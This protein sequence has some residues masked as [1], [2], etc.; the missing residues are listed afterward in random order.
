MCFKQIFD[1]L[2][3]IFILTNSLG[4][5]INTNKTGLNFFDKEELSDVY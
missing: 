1:D 4:S 5:I 3:E 2:S